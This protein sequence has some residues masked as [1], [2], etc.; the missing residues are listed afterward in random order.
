MAKILIV[1]DEADIT[2]ICVMYL[3]GNGYEAYGAKNSKE[4]F[5]VLEK[6]KPNVL[7]LDINLREKY[8][9]VDI[10]KKAIEL[11]PNAQVAMLTGLGDEGIMDESLKCGAKIIL[12]KPIVITELRETIDKLAKNLKPKKRG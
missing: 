10:L 11:E 2:D 8:N 3:E 7:I 12:K 9:G 6:H 4:A 5:E 1:D